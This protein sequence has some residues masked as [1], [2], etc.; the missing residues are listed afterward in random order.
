MTDPLTGVANRAL[1]LDRLAHALA[2]LDR[3]GERAA[4]LYVDLDGFKSVNDRFGHRVGDEVLRSTASRL[5][6]CLRSAD[7]LAR[8]GGDEFVVLCEDLP[9]PEPVSDIA[10]RLVAAV[11]HPLQVG[12]CVVTLSARVGVAASPPPPPADL[13]HQADAAMY[14]AKRRAPRVAVAEPVAGRGVIDL[15]D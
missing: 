8:M 3:T 4:V 7:T 1:L 13:L 14:R 11:A 10:G 5:Q 2:R 15:R 12:G 9:S 6:G